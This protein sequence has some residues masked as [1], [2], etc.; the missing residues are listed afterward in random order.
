MSSVTEVQPTQQEESTIRQ[1]SKKTTREA[2]KPEG[3]QIQRQ[4]RGSDGAGYASEGLG[5]A[6]SSLSNHEEEGNNGVLPHKDG[7]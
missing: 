6:G 3:Q 4:D 5:D 2:T 7:H 1:V